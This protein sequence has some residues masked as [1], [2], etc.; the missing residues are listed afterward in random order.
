MAMIEERIEYGS[1]NDLVAY[2]IPDRKSESKN[3]KHPF[4][5]R[6]HATKKIVSHKPKKFSGDRRTTLELAQSSFASPTPTV[7]HSTFSKN[8]APHL[9]SPKQMNGLSMIFS[10]ESTACAMTQRAISKASRNMRRSGISSCKGFVIWCKIFFYVTPSELTT[11]F[12]VMYAWEISILTVIL[13]MWDIFSDILLLVAI[14]SE[15]GHEDEKADGKIWLSVALIFGF[16]NL[17]FEYANVCR[18]RLY[19]TFQKSCQVYGVSN[20]EDLRRHNHIVEQEKVE[21]TWSQILGTFNRSLSEDAIVMIVALLRG[22]KIEGSGEIMAYSTSLFFSFFALV[23][24]LQYLLST[25]LLLLTGFKYYYASVS[26]FFQY[27]F[28]PSTGFV[29]VGILWINVFMLFFYEAQYQGS[30][31]DLLHVAGV[32]I[33]FVSAFSICFVQGYRS[34][35]NGIHGIRMGPFA[36]TKGAKKVGFEESYDLGESEFYD[37]RIYAATTLH[38]NIAGSVSAHVPIEVT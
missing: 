37:V 35:V 9:S 12:G 17:L 32:L 26:N 21:S 14:E 2:E 24:I 13:D 3:K 11:Y 36:S 1:Q 19:V 4:A 31:R 34:A 25:A 20:I 6:N 28:L 15:G 33:A 23:N 8:S 29:V 16:F 18:G 10:R 5:V 22:K 38:D 7:S 30:K 27:V